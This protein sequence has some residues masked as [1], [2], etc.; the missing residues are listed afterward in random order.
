MRTHRLPLIAWLRDTKVCSKIRDWLLCLTVCLCSASFMSHRAREMGW[1]YAK[2]GVSSES[3]WINL[4]SLCH[5][6][7]VDIDINSLAEFGIQ[8]IVVSRLPCDFV[9]FCGSPPEIFCC[10]YA[11][12]KSIKITDMQL[13]ISCF[14]DVL[15]FPFSVCTDNHVLKKI[16]LWCQLGHS[17][18]LSKSSPFHSILHIYKVAL[19]M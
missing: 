2:Q 16:M 4:A 10:F 18:K 14:H 7:V 6:T 13:C 8:A 9:C 11:L 12:I 15:C 5:L 19:E 1:V 3:A 17:T